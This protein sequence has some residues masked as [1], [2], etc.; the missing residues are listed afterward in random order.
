MAVHSVAGPDSWTYGLGHFWYFPYHPL[1]ASLLA[2]YPSQS[3]QP[4]LFRFIVLISS[5]PAHCLC[6]HSTVKFVIGLYEVCGNGIIILFFILS[7]FFLR[8]YPKG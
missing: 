8:S 6:Y 1:I 2:H 4:K 5:P 3:L 7:L